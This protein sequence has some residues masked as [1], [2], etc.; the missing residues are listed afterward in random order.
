[1]AD[2]PEATSRQD[3]YL[4]YIAE[5]GSFSG[6]GGG[7]DI[8][9]P[10]S[11]ENG[12]TGATT[13]VDA[14]TNLD[15]YSKQEVDD[16]ISSSSI[17]VVQTRGTSE[18]DVM[19]QKAVSA[20]TQLGE[21]TIMDSDSSV[22]FGTNATSTGS[23]S[24]NI[25]VQSSTERTGSIAIGYRAGSY[26]NDNISIGRLSSAG[27]DN[28]QN[29]IAIGANCIAKG[30]NSIA[31]LTGEGTLADDSIAMGVLSSVREGAE[32]GVALGARSE[33][34]ARNSIALGVESTAKEENILSIGNDTA[35]RRI[36]HVTDPV[37]EQD[38]A[39]KKYVDTAIS[40]GGS[41]INVVQTTGESETD[42]MSQK[43]TTDAL[44]KTVYNSPTM[45]SGIDLNT[46]TTAGFYMVDSTCTS[47]P[48]YDSD[49]SLIVST[50]G[51]TSQSDYPVFQMCIP[52]KTREDTS[53]SKNPTMYIRQKYLNVDTWQWTYWLNVS[54]LVQNDTGD[55]YEDTMSQYAITNNFISKNV[56]K[57]SIGETSK[58]SGTGGIAIGQSAE[59]Y[60]TGGISIGQYAFCP[61]P[62]SIALG[63][64]SQATEP[65]VLSVGNMDE[66]RKI[67]N[68]TDPTN[69]QDVATKNYVDTAISAL[70]TKMNL[71]YSGTDTAN[72]VVDIHCG[73]NIGLS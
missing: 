34:T 18:T 4:K 67:I 68:V 54:V 60:Q 61:V 39:T 11:I 49:Y 62:N 21:N 13:E 32:N 66:T 9:L 31:F 23:G 56:S 45:E 29:N 37:N 69:P 72:S 46:K 70:M 33:V 53:G 30:G 57:I 20:I 40:S 41:S 26:Q 65:N 10:V 1:M 14:R 22:V 6:G 55:S 63:A 24:V 16:K 36:I 51:D 35:T 15:V 38:A 44:K 12:G 42:V 47:T 3:I 50:I 19:S 5:N 48:T 64:N 59:S 8:P 71:N 17:N 52:T 73:D 25:G 43:A 28:T 58:A 27:Y 7:S 2:L